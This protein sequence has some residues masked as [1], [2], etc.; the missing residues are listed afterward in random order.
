MQCTLDRLHHFSPWSLTPLPGISCRRR[1]RQAEFSAAKY[2]AHLLLSQLVRNKTGVTLTDLSS[3]MWGLLPETMRIL[4]D[5]NGSTADAAIRVY[6]IQK[7]LKLV[8]IP[9]PMN[10]RITG[11]SMHQGTAAVR[12]LFKTIS[13]IRKL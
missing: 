8:E 3:G 9:V 10:P 11:E 12:N 6:G 13:D 4:L 5:Y 2:I 1:V 7:G